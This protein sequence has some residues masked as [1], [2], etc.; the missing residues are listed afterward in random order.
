MNKQN[1]NSK[2]QGKLKLNDFQ[3]V[4]SLLPAAKKPKALALMVLMIFGMLLEMI[5]VGLVAPIIAV[6]TNPNFIEQYAIVQQ[7]HDLLGNPSHNIVV[8]WAMIL[9]VVIYV[10][11]N[12]YLAFLAWQQSKFV[13]E[14]QADLAKD[15]FQHYLHQ[16]Y[17]FH[18]QRNS[19]D[20]I[21]NLQVELN[22]FM[23]YM[24]SLGL[25]IIAESLVVV[26]LVGLLLYFEPVGALAVFGVFLLAGGVF[27][28]VT[29]RKIIFWGK[30]RQ[31]HEAFR[32]KHV[33]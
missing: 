31:Q 11:K 3:R 18:L 13:F 24:L 27:Q 30:Q 10:F 32:M 12:A 19:A 15:L 16:P 28:W 2:P 4:W 7:F 29:R 17:T 20:L 25:L 26:G 5:G 1:F 21:N 6:V 9:L 22:F 14:T 8:V 33:Q 23:H